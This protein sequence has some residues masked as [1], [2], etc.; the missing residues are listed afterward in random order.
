MSELVDAVEN[1][2][3]SVDSLERTVKSKWN[4]AQWI[5]AILLWYFLSNIAGAVWHSKIRYAIQYG[6]GTDRVV[7]AKIP[8]SDSCAFYAA[9]MGEKYCHHDWESFASPDGA[10]YGNAEQVYVNRPKVED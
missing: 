2:Q 10:N 5:G 9:P 3:R 1:V 4:T 6:V 7:V 8:S